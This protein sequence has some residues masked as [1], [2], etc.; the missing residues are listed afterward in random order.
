VTINQA[1]HKT[2]QDGLSLML[3]G[4]LA[5]GDHARYERTITDTTVLSD[6]LKLLDAQFDVILVDTPAGF[7]ALTTTVLT[8]CRH[9]LVP[10]W[11]DSMAIRAVHQSVRCIDSIRSSANPDL[12]LLG[13]VPMQVDRDTPVPER[14]TLQVLWLGCSSGLDVS[15]PRDE[16]FRASARS[17]RPLAWLDPKPTELIARLESLAGLVW[18]L[19]EEAPSSRSQ[20]D[21]TEPLRIV[22]TL[23]VLEESRSSEIETEDAFAFSPVADS[24]NR[25]STPQ[26]A[27]ETSHDVRA[28]RPFPLGLS[29]TA[30]AAKR[31]SGSAR[32][33]SC[34]TG[35]TRSRAPSRR[36]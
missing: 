35:A 22:H 19:V 20:D 23:R 14:E 32:G 9:A 28:A 1:L 36:S 16:T 3:R 30:C 31:P 17:R 10:A 5:P 4:R 13:L 8:H 18:T 11:A 6:V 27:G 26:S 34:S 15:I 7:G 25:A 2:K 24:T 12:D 33:R 21:S 29:S